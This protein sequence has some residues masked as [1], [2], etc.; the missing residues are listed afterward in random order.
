MLFSDLHEKL[1]GLAHGARV[2]GRALAQAAKP[3]EELTLSE[4]ADRYRRVSAESGSRF[5]GAWSTARTPYLREPMDCLHPDHPARKVTLKFSAQTGK[6]EIPVNWFGYIVDRAPGS[7]MIVLPSLDE[8]IKFNRVKLQPTVDASPQ[9]RHRVRP[10]NSR[11]EAASTTSFKRFAGG[12]A[13]IVTASSSKGLQ[14]VSIRYLVMDEVSEYPLDTDG[15]GSPIDQARARQKSYGDLAK[16]FASS[17]PGLAGTCRISAMYEDGDRRRYYMPCPHCNGYSVLRYENMQ[18]PSPVTKHR[19]TFACQGP[20]CGALIDQAD[21]EQMLAN[22]CWIAT[23]PNDQDFPGAILAPVPDYIPAED[24]E[25]YI[26]PPCEGRCR[27]W[28]PSYALW[29]AYSPMESW[30]DIWQ[31]GV[32][33]KGVPLK[34]KTFT[35]QDL[36]EPYDPTS[37]APDHEKLLAVRRFWPRGTVPYPACALTGFIDVQGDRYEWGVWGWGPGFQ[38]W[39]VDFGVIAKSGDYTADFAY[40]DALGAR[41]FLTPSGVELAPI[42]WGI[43]TGNETQILYDK[44]S[45]RGWLTA[46]KG[47]SRVKAPPLRFTEVSL[48]DRLGRP[49]AGRRLRLGFIGGFD[50]KTAVYKGLS[51]LVAGPRENGQFPNGTLHLPEW[52]GED[53]AKQLTAEVLFD[54][55]AEAKGKAKRALLERPGEHREWRKLP[56]RANEALDIVVGARALAWQE[57]AGEIEEDRWAELVAQAHREKPQTADLFDKPGLKAPEEMPRGEQP[58]RQGQLAPGGWIPRHTHWM[59][60]DR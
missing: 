42:A 8:A 19:V 23:R 55:Q 11:D 26:C 1:P 36:G 54:P 56:G 13:Q 51:A 46:T 14:M 22:G 3:E 27:G 43:D 10:E 50:L 21:R 33:A 59:H 58:Q 32:E 40:I 28:Q 45:G 9:I 24:L 60:R 34:E 37:D 7:M 4:W 2:L 6:S 5:P 12:F 35:Q 47:E 39:L 15:R 44:V 57:G 52:I 30:G 17:T 18:A 53:Y 20:E 29:S 25:R 49:I 38:G 48:R 16:E 41:T 31:R